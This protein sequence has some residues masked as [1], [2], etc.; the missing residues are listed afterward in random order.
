M[1]GRGDLLVRDHYFEWVVLRL[2]AT[3]VE[4]VILRLETESLQNVGIALLRKIS[5]IANRRRLDAEARS[6]VCSD[7]IGVGHDTIGEQRR[8]ILT[9][10]VHSAA[11][12]VPLATAPLDAVDIDGD[13][14]P[15]SS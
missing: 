4:D 10:Q 1:R 9:D 14:N 2:E 12:E 13:G 3:D 11:D 6:I 5:A 8:E 7:H 15:S